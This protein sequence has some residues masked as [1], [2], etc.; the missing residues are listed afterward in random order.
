MALQKN[1]TVRVWGSNHSEER[2]GI[3]AGLN[4][5][6][7]IAAGIS[8]CMALTNDGTVVL[9]GDNSRGQR[10]IPAGLITRVP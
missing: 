9:W 6:V 3:P 7:A 5:F 1:G 2:D 10:D 4:N 8:H